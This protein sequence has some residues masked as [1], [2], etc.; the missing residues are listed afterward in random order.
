MMEYGILIYDLLLP[1]C[2]HQ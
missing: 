2:V 1:N